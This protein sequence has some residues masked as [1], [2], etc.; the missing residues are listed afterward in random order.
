MRDPAPHTIASLYRRLLELE[1]QTAQAAKANAEQHQSI[2][3]WQRNHEQVSSRLV[4]ATDEILSLVAALRWASTTRHVVL[5]L[6]GGL[7]FVTSGWTWLHD[8]IVHFFSGK[9][10]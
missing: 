7:V 1:H 4:A 5:W 8:H 10:H 9:G 3:A 6:A 2:I